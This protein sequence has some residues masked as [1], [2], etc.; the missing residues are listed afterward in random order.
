VIAIGKDHKA[1]SELYILMISMH[2]L[3]RSYDL[4]LGQ[5]ADT[6]GQ[7]TYVVELARALSRHSEVS[8]VDLVTKLIDDTDVSPDYAVPEES[9]G[10]CARIVRLPCGPKKYMRKELLWPHLDQAVDHCLHF[11]RQQGRL[12]D[13]IHSHYADAGY[14]GKQL[15]TL[16]GIPLV[17][18]GHSLGRSK[19]SRL[20]ADGKKERTI[21][22][23]FNFRQ[24]IKTEEEV[25]Q[26]ASLVVTSTRQEI[27][28]Q[29]GMYANHDQRKC[30]VI[31]PGTNN[32]RFSPP[33]RKPINGILKEKIDRF[34][35]DTDKPI[36]L[37]INRP[38]L[39]KNLKGLIAAYGESSSLQEV[40]NLVIVAGMR[41]DIRN[42]EETQQS[43]MNEVLLDVDKYDLWGKVAFPKKITQ[44]EIPELYRLAS[45]RKGIFVNPALTE[46]FGLTLIEAAAS[47]LPIIAPDDGGPKDI[48]SNCRNGLLTNTLDS[49][50][51]ADSIHTALSD[52]KQWKSWSRS[53]ITGVRNNYT[54]DAHVEKY[55]KQVRLL[56]RRD[57]KRIRR[58][59]AMVLHAGKSPMPLV[60]MALISDIDNTLIGD[61]AS[62][63]QLIDWLRPQSQ[64]LA[65]GIATGRSLES[66]LKI[67]KRHRVP[68]PDVLV[69]SV[70][71]E[72]NYGPDLSPDI[73]WSNH[74]RHLWRRDD[75]VNVMS[76]IPGLK[77][78][79]DENQ[80]EFKIS[81]LVSPNLMP[82]VE[83]IY[84][85][86]HGLRL[87]AQVIY[88]H[89]EL[90]DIL[91]VR[92]SKGH[93][94]R[95][96]AY[97]WGLPLKNFIVAGDSG[98]DSEMLVGATRAIVVANHSPEL[99]SL[100]G[101]DHIYFAQAE[102]SAGIIEGLNH[103][104][105]DVVAPTVKIG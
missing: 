103:Y 24:R 60:N 94:V 98:N 76:D 74:I 70:G 96:L 84:R 51:I 45:S 56:H 22:R 32:S 54:W 13:I 23:Q 44:D 57:R 3:I 27:E 75:L 93:A 77:L 9:L 34:L 12:P 26:H 17:H 63:G 81:Y 49:K 61:K 21:E 87:H 80:R 20:L 35:S 1:G 39:R 43:V 7:T 2:G 38:V 71:S 10:G 102:Y 29:Y 59:Q 58:Q 90:L 47:G 52:I 100:R 25:I 101:L 42:M 4:E 16:L 73:G 68:I 18:T 33:S 66:A 30:S 14:V 65:F 104:G 99:E 82:P 40:A 55:M 91:P 6:G 62:L 97:K 19:K 78:Q 79:A 64:K 88:S 53:G 72:I 28:E 8:K 95:Y 36:I 11:L 85:S 31:P 92:A 37:A 69:T 86:L 105:F 46:P 50:A 41:E 83:Q 5:D 15:S 48:I 89:N 67:L